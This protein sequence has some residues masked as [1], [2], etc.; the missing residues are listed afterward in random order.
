MKIKVGTRSSKLAMAQ[1]LWVARQLEEQ[2]PGLE[3]ELCPISTKGDQIQHLPLD[4]IG[5]KG[6]FTQAIE[7]ALLDG[8]VDFA[9]HSMKDMPTQMDD[10][11][12]FLCV[13]RREDPRDV[14]VAASGYT[15][16]SDLPQWA[17]IGCGSKRRICQLL[18]LRP[19]LRICPIRGNIDTR[20]GKIATEGLDGVILAA[21]GIHRLGLEQRITSYFSPQEMIPACAQGALAIQARG[22]REDLAAL[23]A[24]LH[25]QQAACQ[26]EAERAYLEAVGGG[27][28][29][30]VGAI[31][32]V[33]EDTLT[34]RALL[35]CEDGS[36]WVTGE[37]SGPK[38]QCRLIGEKLAAQLKEKLEEAGV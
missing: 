26:V 18:A 5:D 25:D 36:K 31:A 4:K 7:Q 16:L 14:L 21:A 35:G 1:T 34:L 23:F 10:R 30:P 17:K 20:M 6:L 9:V 15:G 11:L 28:H 33:F 38:D 32:Q 37:L 22:D 27:C 3:V 2:H 19:D 13:P 29:L 24:V 8:T 12:S